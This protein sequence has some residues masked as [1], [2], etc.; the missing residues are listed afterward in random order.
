M[1]RDYTKLVGM[2]LLLLLFAVQPRL[3]YA[4]SPPAPGETPLAD[5]GTNLSG[6]NL[7]G[8]LFGVIG[9]VVGVAGLIVASQKV[10]PGRELV[11]ALIEVMKVDEFREQLR[12]EILDPGAVTKIVATKGDFVT[13]PDLD[14]KLEGFL[15]NREGRLRLLDALVLLEPKDIQSLRQLILDE[16]AVTQMVNQPETERLDTVKDILR[17]VRRATIGGT[18]E[19]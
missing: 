6:N 16:S 12:N 13:A 19:T 7:P 9:I 3:L 18:E 4:Q 14:R 17:K 1:R 11:D 2:L 5:N 8:I 15:T 10:G